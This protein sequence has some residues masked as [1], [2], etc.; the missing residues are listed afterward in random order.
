MTK[1]QRA[2]N[3]LCC[4]NNLSEGS[5]RVCY[6]QVDTSDF[7]SIKAFA[8]FFNKREEKLDFLINNAG[9]AKGFS[10]QQK[11]KTEIYTR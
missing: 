4:E 11:T 3:K 7:N 2:V 10:R 8:D 5:E 6:Y 1:L 9:M